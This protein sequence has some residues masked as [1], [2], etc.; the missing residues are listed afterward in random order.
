M[1]R[2]TALLAEAAPTVD[3][4]PLINWTIKTIV[5]VIL[6]GL[7]VLVISGARKGKLSDNAAT[8]VNIMIGAAIITGAGLFFAFS[9]SITAMLTGAAS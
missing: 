8:V 1:G 3:T 2:L 6:L 9:K 7:G 5:P 4:T